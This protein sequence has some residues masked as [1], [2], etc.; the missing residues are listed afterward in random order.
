MDEDAG[1]AAL[2]EPHNVED[3]EIPEQLLDEQ[4]RHEQEQTL[5]NIDENISYVPPSIESNEDKSTYTSNASVVKLN[6]YMTSSLK[7]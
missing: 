1:E 3:I 2:Y 4:T 7:S 6:T 5:L